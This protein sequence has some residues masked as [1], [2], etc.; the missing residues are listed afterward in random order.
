MGL[1]FILILVAIHYG[2]KDGSIKNDYQDNN[3]N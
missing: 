3:L 1:I 2:Y